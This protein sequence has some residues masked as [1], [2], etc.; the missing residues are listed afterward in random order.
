MD[1][2]SGSNRTRAELFGDSVEY[3][4]ELTSRPESTSKA[5]V[6]SGLN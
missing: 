1:V 5:V 4:I 2:V 6:R 3:N